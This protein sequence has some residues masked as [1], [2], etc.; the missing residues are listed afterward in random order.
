[1][2]NYS[3]RLDK[4]DFYR[5]VRDIESTFDLNYTA[6]RLEWFYNQLSKYTTEQVRLAIKQLMDNEERIYKNQNLYSMIRKRIPSDGFYDN[7]K[8]GKIVG[9][10]CSKC[11][12]IIPLER[13]DCECIDIET[14]KMT[15]TEKQSCVDIL[16]RLGCKNASDKLQ[17]LLNKSKHVDQIPF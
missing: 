13:T 7:E 15:L 17:D 6:D 1:M 4:D 12:K 11:G 10:V 14:A 3:V 9:W 2:Q 8:R 16:R 5:M